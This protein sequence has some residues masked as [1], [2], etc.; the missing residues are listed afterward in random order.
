MPE[1]RALLLVDLQNDFCP[2]GALPVPHG[3]AVIPPL[4]RL[5][6]RLAAQ[7]SPVYAS[8]DWHPAETRH[9]AAF[10]GLWPVHCV[11][12]TRGAAF[13]PDLVLP[14]GT[15]ILSKGEDPERDDYSAIVARDAAGQTLADRLRRDGVSEL[16]VGGLATDYCVRASVLDALALGVVVTVISDG[17][18]GVDLKPGDSVH[19]CAEMASAG[20]RFAPADDL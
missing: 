10:G 13:H 1:A 3:D 8:R 18:A 19:A 6:A 15:V 7:G 20:A 4:N 2:G 12:G 5:A 11:Q 14:T 17:I 16:L 9:F